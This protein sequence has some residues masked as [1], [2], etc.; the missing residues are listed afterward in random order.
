MLADEGSALARALFRTLHATL[1]FKH[2]PAVEAGLSQQREYTF[3]V[4]L[5]VAQRAETAGPLIPGLIPAIDADAPARPE[6]GV[7]DV[8]AADPL[9]IQLDKRAVVELLQQEMARIV[10][11][12]SVGWSSV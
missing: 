3:E 8:K 4:D 10:V 6:L 1:P 2:R 7:L 9:A 12:A 11:D 5:A